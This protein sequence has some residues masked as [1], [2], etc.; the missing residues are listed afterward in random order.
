MQQLLVSPTP[1]PEPLLLV[2]GLFLVV[3]FL[4]FNASIAASNNSFCK[5]AHCLIS[6]I[7]RCNLTDGSR[8][9]IPNPEQGASKRIRSKRLP[10]TNTLVPMCRPS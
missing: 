2:A 1:T 5:W 6:V 9:M 8:D 7:V 10:P 4:Y 3:G